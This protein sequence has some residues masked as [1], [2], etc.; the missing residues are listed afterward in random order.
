MP[1]ALFDPFKHKVG[2]IWDVGNIWARTYFDLGDEVP[3]NP[4]LVINHNGPEKVYLN[5]ELI[6]NLNYPSRRN[7]FIPIYSRAN[8]AWKRNDKNIIS[9][10]AN[11][12]YLDGFLEVGLID[13]GEYPASF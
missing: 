12:H 2:S 9:I 3:E 11:T 1:F 7:R 8:E 13:I 10:Y 6:C 4:Y 5:G